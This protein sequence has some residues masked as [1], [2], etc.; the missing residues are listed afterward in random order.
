MKPFV[1]KLLLLAFVTM[2]IFSCSVDSELQDI[3]DEI[4]RQNNSLESEQPTVKIKFEN[5]SINAEKRTS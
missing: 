5:H 4:E 3:A 2:T 1:I